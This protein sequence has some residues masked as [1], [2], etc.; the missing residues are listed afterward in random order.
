MIE[1]QKQPGEKFPRKIKEQKQPG[2]KFPQ[3]I[4]EQ[5]QPGEK[6]PRKIKEQKQL[7]KG[8]LELLNILTKMRL[9]SQEAVGVKS[10]RETRENNQ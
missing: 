6:F 4:E 3:M 2:E 5:K 9:N 8:F 7:G 1:E 10:N